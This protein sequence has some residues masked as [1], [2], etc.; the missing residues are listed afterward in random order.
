MVLGQM[1]AQAMVDYFQ[2]LY[3]WLVEENRGRQHTLP[4]L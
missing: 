1:D 4:A 2:P 3:D